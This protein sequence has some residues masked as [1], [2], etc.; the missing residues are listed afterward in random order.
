[1]NLQLA[2]IE[3]VNPFSGLKIFAINGNSRKQKNT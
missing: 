3:K 2:N 1:M